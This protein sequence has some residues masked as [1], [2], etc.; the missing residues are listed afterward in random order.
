MGY[1]FEISATEYDA[2]AHAVFENFETHFVNDTESDDDDEDFYEQYEEAWKETP[3]NIER[4]YYLEA[5][6]EI[7][8]KS[9]RK[10]PW[11]L[12]D[13]HFDT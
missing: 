8:R 12:Y 13:S 1:E 9:Y 6:V 10:M 3:C 5:S 7:P 11:L 2:Q 4:N